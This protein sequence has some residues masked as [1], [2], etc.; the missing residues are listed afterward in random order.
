MKIETV[1]LLS[2]AIIRCTGQIVY[3]P[4]ATRLQ[5]TA[6]R[7]LAECDSCILDLEGVT[8]VDAR[9]LGTLV[10]LTRQARTRHCSLSLANVNGR[11]QKALRLTRLDKVLEFTYRSDQSAIERRPAA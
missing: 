2:V 6:E 1:R 4:E 10:E 3:G 11:L 5:E 7:L 9:G 8:Q